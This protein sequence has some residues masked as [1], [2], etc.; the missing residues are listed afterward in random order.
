MKV[1]CG[2]ITTE[3]RGTVCTS[4]VLTA[5]PR[6]IPVYTVPLPKNIQQFQKF[7]KPKKERVDAA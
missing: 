6:C 5:V 7:L 4:G 1:W 3:S 2:T